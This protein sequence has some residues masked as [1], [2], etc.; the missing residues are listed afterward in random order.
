MEQEI[1]YQVCYGEPVNATQVVRLSL[2]GGNGVAYNV[3]KACRASRSG[4]RDANRQ[5]RNW[6]TEE[7][8]VVIGLDI[9]LSNPTP[10][11]PV[12]GQVDTHLLG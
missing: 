2:R 5:G 11:A 8:E 7:Q 6:I 12:L 3:C 10:R 4:R 9:C 1:A